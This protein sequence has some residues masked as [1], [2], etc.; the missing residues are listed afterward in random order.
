[1]TFSTTADFAHQLDAEDLLGH[2]REK[3]HLPIG[4]DSKPLIYFAGNSLGLMPKSARQVV[5]PGAR[6]G[7][8]GEDRAAEQPGRPGEE[9]QRRGEQDH[10]DELRHDVEIPWTAAIWDVCVDHCAPTQKPSW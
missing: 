1:M 2:F 7:H 10:E 4:K 9:C 5:E 3:F 6:L 8:A